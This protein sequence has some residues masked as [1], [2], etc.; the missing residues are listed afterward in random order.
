MIA[1]SNKVHFMKCT[2]VSKVSQKSKI[3]NNKVFLTIGNTKKSN[4]L[5]KYIQTVQNAKKLTP[6]NVLLLNQ[7]KIPHRFFIL[8][9]EDLNSW[10]Q[11]RSA[12]Y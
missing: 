8:E 3:V 2:I 5:Q 9:P 10:S 4:S 6:K 12:I 1:E 11:N 7:N